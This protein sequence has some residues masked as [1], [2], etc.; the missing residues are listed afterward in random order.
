ME[1]PTLRFVNNCSYQQCDT[2][3]TNSSVLFKIILNNFDNYEPCL[4]SFAC[5][6]I[7]MCWKHRIFYT[8]RSKR[9]L[10]LIVINIQHHLYLTVCCPIGQ[11]IW[12]PTSGSLHPATRLSLPCSPFVESPLWCPSL[13]EESRG[14]QVKRNVLWWTFTEENCHPECV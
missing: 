7:K 13:R 14:L 1:Q 9:E 12:A 6:L 5:L 2:N 3:Y 4:S 8:Y 10:G 11:R